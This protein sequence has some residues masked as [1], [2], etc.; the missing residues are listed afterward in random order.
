VSENVLHPKLNTLHESLF[1]LFGAQ[2][3]EEASTLLECVL[4]AKTG[5]GAARPIREYM[6]WL[7]HT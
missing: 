1:L 4:P 2:P 6:Y 7:S 3:S 5:Q